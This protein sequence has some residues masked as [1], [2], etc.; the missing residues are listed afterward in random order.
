MQYIMT[1]ENIKAYAKNLRLEERS[2]ATVIKYNLAL[3]RLYDY[4]PEGKSVTK[5]I[6]LAWKDYIQAGN[7]ASTVNVMI[8]AVN[9]FC[10]FLGWVGLRIK[11]VKTQ[12]N[13]YRDPRRELTKQDY[14]CLLQAALA[15][16]NLRIFYLMQTL[17]ASGIRISELPFITVEA[18][19]AGSATVNCKGKLRKV[20][21]PKQLRKKLLEYCRDRNITSGSVFVAKS[22]NPMSRSNIWRDLRKLCKAAGVDPHK[23]F[24]HNFRHLFAVT[25]YRQEKD[26]AK[27]ADLLGHASINTTRIYIM[28]SGEEHERQIERLGL[29]L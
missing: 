18:L 8:S 4:L 14:M 7:A 3:K 23:V 5:E 11:Q 26:V 6:L 10:Q 17:A 22:G 29:V 13:V 25:Y 9:G 1:E 2:E 21:I 27:L 20:F 24:P 16:G 12:R 15:S 28:E 19:K